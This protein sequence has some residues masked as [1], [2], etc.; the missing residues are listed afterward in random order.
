VTH[1]IAGNVERHGL[2]KSTSLSLK[3]KMGQL[4][5]KIQGDETVAFLLALLGCGYVTPKSGLL[6]AQPYSSCAAG[7]GVE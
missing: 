4:I 5:S 2:C 1:N 6:L 7:T 3:G